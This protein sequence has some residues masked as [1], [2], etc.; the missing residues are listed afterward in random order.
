MMFQILQQQAA[1]G[2]LGASG[3]H[4][5]GAN[6]PPPPHPSSRGPHAAPNHSSPTTAKAGGDKGKDK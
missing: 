4:P 2:A 3:A 1:Y 5:P 6:A